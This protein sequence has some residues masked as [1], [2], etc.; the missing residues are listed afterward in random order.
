M[1]VLGIDPG[2]R[3]VGWAVLE[4]DR[5]SIAA[6]GFGCLD[7][8]RVQGGP[9]GRARAI[10]TGITEVIRRFEPACMAIEEAFFGKNVQ[11]ALRIGEGRGFA[12]AA[13][14]LA[15]LPVSEYAPTTVKKAA[16]G[17]GRAHKSQVQEMMR[18][19]LGLGERPEPEDAADALAVAW[20]HLNQPETG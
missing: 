8:S 1:R 16:V 9:A 13:A 2:T 17:H 19:A 14:A 6:L 18:I 3:H 10:C 7:V 11:A 5:G 15:G 20:C 12:I 4:T